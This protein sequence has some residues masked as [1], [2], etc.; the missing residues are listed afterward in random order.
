MGLPTFQAI[1]IRLLLCQFTQTYYM[2]FPNR[3]IT[4]RGK[5]WSCFEVSSCSV[6]YR[7][8]SPVHGISMHRERQISFAA[9]NGGHQGCIGALVLVLMDKGMVGLEPSTNLSLIPFKIADFCITKRFL[10]KP[11]QMAYS[12]LRLQG[13]SLGIKGCRGF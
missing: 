5:V 6:G 8:L 2:L 1:W 11:L 4:E 9:T 12:R 3:Y 7:F 10:C 13:R